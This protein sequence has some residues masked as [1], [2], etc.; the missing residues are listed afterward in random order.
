MYSLPFMCPN[1]LWGAHS[2]LLGGYWGF[3]SKGMWPVVVLRLSMNVAILPVP[4]MHTSLSVPICLYGTCRVNITFA[5]LCRN[6]SPTD[7]FIVY[8][9]I[10]LHFFFCIHFGLAL[11][12][13][14]WV[15]CFL[16]A[17][18][19]H[20][21]FKETWSW[22]HRQLWIVTQKIV[23]DRTSASVLKLSAVSWSYQSLY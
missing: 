5:F 7:N 4:Y 16:A 15:I 23:L 8:A 17:V 1:W 10:K 18:L 9:V 3:Y 11:I 20:I 21:N 19:L 12:T 2:L 14:V 22:M 6:T 13:R